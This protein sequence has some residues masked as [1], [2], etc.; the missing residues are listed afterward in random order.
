MYQDTDMNNQQ[1]RT[2]YDMNPNFGQQSPDLYGQGMGGA[3]CMANPYGHADPY[4]HSNPY[5]QPNPY[6][7]QPKPD[8]SAIYTEEY[9]Q[10][11]IKTQKKRKTKTLKGIAN[12]IA[13]T[14]II[15]NVVLMLMILSTLLE[16]YSHFEFSGAWNYYISDL[17]MME[18]AEICKSLIAI[19]LISIMAYVVMMVSRKLELTSA[20]PILA[21]VINSALL[22]AIKTYYNGYEMEERIIYNDILY[23]PPYMKRE[24]HAVILLVIISVLYIALILLY[25]LKGYRWA[26]IIGLIAGLGM[27]ACGVIALI[28]YYIFQLYFMPVANYTA[29]VILLFLYKAAYEDENTLTGLS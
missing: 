7:N 26:A 29:Y 14:G 19:S 21:C 4:T 25:I 1:E 2:N 5:E 18:G 12:I 6:Y 13:G 15:A 16:R 17:G 8:M 23:F 24:E 3:P 27:T 9:Q 11:Y 10:Q 28:N 22:V 20:Y